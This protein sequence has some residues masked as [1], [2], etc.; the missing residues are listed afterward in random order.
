[1]EVGAE[2][3][4][5]AESAAIDDGTGGEVIKDV[6][7]PAPD[8]ASPVLS[9]TFVIEAVDLCY[10]ARLM[11][12]ADEGHSFRVADLEDEQEKE[13]FDAVETTVDKV[14]CTR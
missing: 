3:T 8:V 14:A 2:P 7:A 10:L 5:H 1:M 13:C 6:T 12:A 4:V 9:L 11:V